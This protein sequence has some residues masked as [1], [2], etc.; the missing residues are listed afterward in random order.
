[1]HVANPDLRMKR[2]LI[3]LSLSPE[4]DD[5]LVNAPATLSFHAFVWYVV[6]VGVFAVSL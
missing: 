3:H 2:V 6:T 5:E 1:M 4:K